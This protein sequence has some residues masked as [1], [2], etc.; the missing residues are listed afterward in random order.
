MSTPAT[1]VSPTA[2]FTRSQPY[3]FPG[4]VDMHNLGHDVSCAEAEEDALALDRVL[5]PEEDP[6]AKAEIVRPMDKTPRP[7]TPPAPRRIS[8]QQM[9]SRSLT[10]THTWDDYRTKPMGSVRR[11]RNSMPASPVS[12][13]ST[14]PSSCSVYHGR[15]GSPF[16]DSP[17]TPSRPSPPSAWSPFSTPVEPPSPPRPSSTP[18]SSPELPPSIQSKT[19]RGR[20]PRSPSS[21]T[22]SAF[23]LPP[24][25]LPSRLPPPERALPSPPLPS[26]PTSPPPPPVPPKDREHVARAHQSLPPPSSPRTFDSPSETPG[27]IRS[28][29]EA[30]LRVVRLNMGH[31]TTLPLGTGIRDIFPDVHSGDENDASLLTRHQLSSTSSLGAPWA[32]SVTGIP[33][34]GPASATTPWLIRPITKRRS[35][36]S[37]STVTAS[38]TASAVY[39][40]VQDWE[41]AFQT[42]SEASAA[43]ADSENP[44]HRVALKLDTHSLAAST[45][46]AL[47][48]LSPAD[49]NVSVPES[50]TSAVSRSTFYTARDSLRS[51]P[52][53]PMRPQKI[54][55]AVPDS[56]C[57]GANP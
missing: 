38:P 37:T 10:R 22:M 9:P 30:N 50:C 1:P 24:R 25:T 18:P 4:G 13:A 14:F 32:G 6:F 23:P 46:S 41:S 52:D 12:T 43:A 55:W 15:E 5:T 35:A 8:S 53:S 34:R 29:R 39:E 26:P 45:S 57:L 36:D 19:V 16:A 47:L 51:G 56:P 54:V 20:S 49:S 7:P 31:L 11:V 27:S 42:I 48:P 2:S 44:S 17:Y 3:V 28:N 21:P 40:A 33:R